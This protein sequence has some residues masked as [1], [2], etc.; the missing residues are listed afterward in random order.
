MAYAHDDENNNTRKRRTV[1]EW[2]LLTAPP[3]QEKG[4]EWKQLYL[5]RKDEREDGLD[6]S[7]TLTSACQ[8]T[9]A[10]DLDRPPARRVAADWPQNMRAAPA[11]FYRGASS[12]LVAVW[13][14]GCL[15]APVVKMNFWARTRMTFMLLLKRTPIHGR[16]L[17]NLTNA[18]GNSRKASTP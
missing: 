2:K 1:E 14:Q 15:N 18:W 17:K 6:N 4:S 9:N 12:T 11:K 7:A 3:A 5:F 13:F 10:G 16:S 8:G